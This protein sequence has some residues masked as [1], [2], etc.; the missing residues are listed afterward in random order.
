MMPID[1]DDDVDQCDVEVISKIPIV[2]K[3]Q[4]KSL[5]AFDHCWC[6]YYLKFSNFHIIL[7]SYKCNLVVYLF[8][9]VE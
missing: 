7:T 3:D 1:D 8:E 4:N 2:D 6:L 5:G 9:D